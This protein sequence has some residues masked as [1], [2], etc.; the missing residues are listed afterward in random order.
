MGENTQEPLETGV[1]SLNL[2]HRR[3]QSQEF[4]RTIVAPHRRPPRFTK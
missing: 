3:R 2:G 4:L 1:F